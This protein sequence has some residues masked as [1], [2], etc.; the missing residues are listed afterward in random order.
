MCLDT[1]KQIYSKPTS[2]EI[3]GYKLM[4]QH[5][6]FKDSLRAFYQ[7]DQKFELNKWS[8]SIKDDNLCT[9]VFTEYPSGFHFFKNK[10][11]ALKYFKN[12]GDAT[13]SLYMLGVLVQIKARKL[14]AKG[15]EKEGIV[16]IA[17]EIKPIKIIKTVEEE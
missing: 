3:I 16:Y 9:P 2:T 4:E 6:Q 7:L 14:V 5:S 10:K 12:N 8:K 1:V 15:T 11:V 17:K 13:Y